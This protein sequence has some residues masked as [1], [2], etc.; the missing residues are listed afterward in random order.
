[1]NKSTR[2]LDEVKQAI[3]GH[4]F[5][6]WYLSDCLPGARNVISDHTHTGHLFNQYHKQLSPAP[7]GTSVASYGSMHATY[8]FSSLSMLLC[9]VLTKP[10]P[11]TDGNRH[12]TD[13]R[14]WSSHS[15]RQGERVVII[16]CG[17]TGWTDPEFVPCR[18]NFE[19]WRV[20]QNGLY[21]VKWLHIAQY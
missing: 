12:V 19:P 21:K 10:S 7:L 1:M 16:F 20:P 9:S 3:S 15:G 11:Q 8:T 2:S 17:S 5:C 13:A 6:L 18:I 14:K 4:M